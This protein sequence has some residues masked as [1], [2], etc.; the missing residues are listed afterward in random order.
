MSRL[1][2]ATEIADVAADLGLAGAANPV[3]AILLHC[4]RRIDGWVAEARGVTT[5]G[6]LEALVTGKLQARTQ[7][8][9][10]GGDRRRL[11][12]SVRLR[13]AAA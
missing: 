10:Q 5:I 4:R 3:Q 1:E 9:G 6:Q 12:K 8:G 11:A 7:E 13:G 2:H